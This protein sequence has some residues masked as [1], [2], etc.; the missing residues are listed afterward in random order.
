MTRWRYWMQWFTDL[1]CF[2]HRLWIQ[3]FNAFDIKNIRS[4]QHT[5]TCNKQ[6]SGFTFILQD[7][8]SLKSCGNLQHFELC[9]KLI[10]YN[11]E[12]HFTQMCRYL[13]WLICLRSWVFPSRSLRHGGEI[14]SNEA[15]EDEGNWWKRECWRYA[16]SRVRIGRPKRM[17]TAQ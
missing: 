4:M 17:R 14:V 10:T 2:S 1:Q 12:S 15:A 5:T 16:V 3:C 11:M 8:Y 9:Y 6:P 7:R 13:R